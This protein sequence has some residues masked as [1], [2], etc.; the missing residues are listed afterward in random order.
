MRDLSDGSA[1]PVNGATVQGDFL[2]ANWPAR[3]ARFTFTVSDTTLKAHAGSIAQ[4][5]GSVVYGT[6]QPGATFALSQPF[7]ILPQ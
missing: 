1:I 2:D 6:S 5:F 4:A 7:Q 3:A